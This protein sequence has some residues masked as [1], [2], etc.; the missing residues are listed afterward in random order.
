MSKKSLS[1][2]IENKLTKLDFLNNLNPEKLEMLNLGDNNFPV[3]DLTIFTPFTE[4]K[5][6]RIAEVH[7]PSNFVGSLK[8]LRNLSKLEII[9]IGGT[10]ISHGLEYLPDSIK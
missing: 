6:L 5:R 8:P 4:L 2:K 1:K 10:D 7:K 9:S 3:Q